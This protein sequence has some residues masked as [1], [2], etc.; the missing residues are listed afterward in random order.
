MKSEL[1]LAGPIIGDHVANPGPQQ[2]QLTPGFSLS[3]G[4]NVGHAVK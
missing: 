4:P 2:G 1:I 3:L